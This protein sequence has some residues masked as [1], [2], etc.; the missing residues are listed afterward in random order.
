MSELIAEDATFQAW[1]STFDVDVG[2]QPA[3]SFYFGLAGSE[4][5]RADWSF[6]LPDELD[7]AIRAYLTNGLSSPEPLIS[8]GC[9]RRLVKIDGTPIYTP[10][11]DRTIAGNN[12]VVCF[13]DDLSAAIDAVTN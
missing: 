2:D 6:D 5:I 8:L 7:T 9:M 4:A 13:V 3:D 1:A 12:G 10:R 11:P